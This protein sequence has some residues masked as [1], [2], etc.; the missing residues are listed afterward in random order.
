MGAI[1]HFYDSD[2][3]GDDDYDG[4]ITGR[5]CSRQALMNTRQQQTKYV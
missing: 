4:R 3:E 1:F 2:D 5:S